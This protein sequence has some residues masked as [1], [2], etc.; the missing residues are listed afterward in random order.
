M[1]IIS[2][3]TNNELNKRSTYSST[4][5]VENPYPDDYAIVPS[6]LEELIEQT[7]GYCDIKLN[8]DG[9][10]VVSF[11]AREIPVIEEPEPPIT[12]AERLRADIDYLAI[13]TGVTL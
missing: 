1:L 12:E 6:Y 5:W 10:E 2:K 9:T 3:S 8:K 7:Q 11:T 4:A 13:M